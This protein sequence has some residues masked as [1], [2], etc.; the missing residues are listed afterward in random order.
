LD[1]SAHWEACCRRCGR[2]CYEKIEQDDGIYYTD[3][4]CDKL[5][6]ASRQCTV[7]SE[8]EQLRPGCRR[9]TPELVRRGLL[10]ADCPYVEGID[11][12]PAPILPD[13]A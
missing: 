9:L 10:P 6:L 2:C 5:D 12:Y 13:K 8:R 3:V 7:Y 11:D 1:R 4:P